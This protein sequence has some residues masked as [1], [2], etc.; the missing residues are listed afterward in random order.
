MISLSIVASVRYNIFLAENCDLRDRR[1]YATSGKVRDAVEDLR[2]GRLASPKQWNWTRHRIDCAPLF[3]DV[4]SLLVPL[5]LLGLR[6]RVIRA[7]FR[8]VL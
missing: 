4:S 5:V 2:E 3:R 8:G 6:A 7:R 1:F